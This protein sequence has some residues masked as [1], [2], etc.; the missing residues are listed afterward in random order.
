M[1]YKTV[2]IKK[3]TVKYITELSNLKHLQRYMTSFEL[4]FIWFER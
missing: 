2:Q 3:L 4:G 1:R